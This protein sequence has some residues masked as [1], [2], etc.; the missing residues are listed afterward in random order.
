LARY[1][2]NLATNES[3]LSRSRRRETRGQ[4]ARW[5]LRG[6]GRYGI[7]AIDQE[8]SARLLVRVSAFD[9]VESEPVEYDDMT[10]TAKRIEQE[11]RELPLEDMLVLH[12]QLVTS[13]HEK[14]EAQKLDATFREE[15][16]RR[17]KEIDSGAAEGVDALQAL[18][19]M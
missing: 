4:S 1:A 2:R 16:Q 17:V 12:D 6:A 14:E 15:I 7:A 18:K 8:R 19:E 13:I 3:K 10:A 11:I 9:S 5:I